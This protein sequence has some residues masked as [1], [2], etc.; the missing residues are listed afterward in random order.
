MKMQI[1]RGRGPYKYIGRFKMRKE[2]IFYDLHNVVP[3]RAQVHHLTEPR[4]LASGP[5]ACLL[6]LG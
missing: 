5:P 3:T 4:A 6:R 1:A 2:E